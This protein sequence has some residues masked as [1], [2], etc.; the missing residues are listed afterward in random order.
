MGS[1][2]VIGVWGQVWYKRDLESICKSIVKYE[3]SEKYKHQTLIGETK[4]SSLR[5]IIYNTF[6]AGK[7]SHASVNLTLVSGLTGN[8]FLLY[9][10]FES[11]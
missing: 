4:V 7:Q 8:Y 6:T 3:S 9:T 11:L 5:N 2:S 1:V 10:R